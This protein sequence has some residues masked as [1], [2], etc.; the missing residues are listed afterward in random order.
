MPLLGCCKIAMSKYL[1]NAS[2]MVVFLMIQID[3]IF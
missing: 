3:E 1:L 2:L